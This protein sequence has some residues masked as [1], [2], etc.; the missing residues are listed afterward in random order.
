MNCQCARRGVLPKTVIQTKLLNRT[1]VTIY[2]Q[3]HL[4]HKTA[5]CRSQL[6][7]MLSEILNNQKTIIKKLTDNERIASKQMNC[8]SDTMN[9]FDEVLKQTITAV[10]AGLPLPLTSVEGLTTFDV[11]LIDGAIQDKFPS[12]CISI[13]CALHKYNICN[14]FPAKLCPSARGARLNAYSRVTASQINFWGCRN[15]RAFRR[16]TIYSL[17]HSTILSRFGRGPEVWRK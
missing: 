5:H 13:I 16:T 4:R 9:P 12:W 10:P 3:C 14:E 17:M 1:P 11:S 2:I 15:M 7:G 6:S 8:L